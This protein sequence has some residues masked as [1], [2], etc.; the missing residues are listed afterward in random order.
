MKAN[1]RD[2]DAF[3]YERLLFFLR[4][5]AVSRGIV[6]SYDVPDGAALQ[7]INDGTDLATR[8]SFS[9]GIGVSNDDGLDF[10]GS[11]GMRSACL[12]TCQLGPIEIDYMTLGIEF[13]AAKMP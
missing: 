3:L 12:S 4:A 9:V 10:N 6:A 8:P 13:R 11:S 2:G 7:T 1:L 5:L